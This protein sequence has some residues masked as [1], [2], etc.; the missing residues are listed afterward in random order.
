[1][2]ETGYINVRRE[3]RGIKTERLCAGVLLVSLLLGRR[4]LLQGCESNEKRSVRGEDEVIPEH[5]RTEQLLR[6]ERLVVHHRGCLD[7]ILQMRAVWKKQPSQ[8]SQPSRTESA[9]VDLTHSPSQEVSEVVEI[10]VRLVLDVDDA[11]PVLAATDRLTVNHH[12]SLRTDDSERHHTL[13][14]Q[15]ATSRV[16]KCWLVQ[17]CE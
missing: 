6:P 3:K 12:I 9:P 5:A 16:R 7:Q 10:A 14:S 2:N 15:N 1:M 17:P 11:P 8:P 13:H 4:R